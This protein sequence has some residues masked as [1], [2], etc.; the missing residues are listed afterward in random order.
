MSTNLV[1]ID[2]EKRYR[3]ENQLELLKL[4][5]E[6]RRQTTLSIGISSI[7]VISLS[8]LIKNSDYLKFAVAA[9]LILN[10]IIL[11]YDV[12]LIKKSI[13]NAYLELKKVLGKD[14]QKLDVL[15][16]KVGWLHKY[17][18]EIST[19]LFTGIILFFIYLLL[20]THA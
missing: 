10:L 8:S 9:L 2:A 16:A 12:F 4:F 11:W 15:N 14:G 6:A 13:K 18:T 17:F 20:W 5:V 7:A 3:A 19:I 1:S